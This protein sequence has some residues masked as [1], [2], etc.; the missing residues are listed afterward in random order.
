MVANESIVYEGKA[1][2]LI[3]TA[4]ENIYEQIQSLSGEVMDVQIP[5]QE[6]VKT[7][8]KIKNVLNNINL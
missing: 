7:E 6:D 8:D 5:V 3:K 2:K 4:D 1:K